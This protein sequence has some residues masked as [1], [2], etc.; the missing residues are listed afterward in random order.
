MYVVPCSEELDA[1]LVTRVTTYCRS[2]GDPLPTTCSTLED[3]SLYPDALIRSSLPIST[4]TTTFYYYW[5][6]ETIFLGVQADV[7]VC[8]APNMEAWLSPWWPQAQHIPQP[9]GAGVVCWKCRVCQGH[10]HIVIRLEWSLTRST[11]FPGSLSTLST[12]TFSQF[13]TSSFQTSYKIK[14]ASN[15]NVIFI[16]AALELLRFA[17]LPRMAPG[18]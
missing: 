18:M 16:Y 12:F 15:I 3:E 5:R 10:L 6:C 17:R 9:E 11:L 8:T 2:T 14:I 1:E 4:T 7:G 13:T